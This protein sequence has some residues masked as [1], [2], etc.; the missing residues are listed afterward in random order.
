MLLLDDLRRA[1]SCQHPPGRQPPGRRSS[2][3]L[4]RQSPDRRQAGRGLLG[5]VDAGNDELEVKV[6]EAGRRTSS[7]STRRLGEDAPAVKLVNLIAAAARS[8]RRP[9]D[10]HIEPGD[11]L[12]RVRYRVDGALHEVMTPP[13]A[14]AQRAHLA[15]QDPGA[16]RHRRALRAAGRQVPDPLRGPHH[17]LPPLDPAGRRRRE[18]RDAYPRRRQPGAEARDAGL[19]AAVARGHPQGDQLALRDDPGH[20]VRRARA[21]RRRCTRA[22]TRSRSPTSTSSRSRTRSST[23]STASTRCRSTPSAG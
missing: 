21:S 9:R 7:S 18:G 16:A 15:P 11:K 22:C 2:S 17:R 12:V 5:E 8:R 6:E 23:A 19:R 20:R 4:E 1:P 14:H 13:K 10:I 3:A